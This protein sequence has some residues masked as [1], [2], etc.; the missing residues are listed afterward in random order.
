[1]SNFIEFLCDMSIL[2]SSKLIP[3]R[4]KTDFYQ[5]EFTFEHLRYSLGGDRPSQTTKHAL[6]HYLIISSKK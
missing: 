3:L 1:M 2:Q 6:S 4:S 5:L